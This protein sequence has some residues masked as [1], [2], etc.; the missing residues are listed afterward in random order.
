MLS[1]PTAPAFSDLCRTAAIRR[2]HHQHR[3][4]AFG[5][6]GNEV[7]AQLEAFVAGDSPPLLAKGHARTPPVR[8]AMVFSGNGSQWRGMGQDL[9]ADP[10]IARCIDRVDATISRL[11]GWSVK[12]ALSS[13]EPANL[14]DRTEIAQPAL[15]ALQVAMLEWLAAHGIE[16]EAML[17]HSVGEVSAAYGAGILSLAEACRVIVERSRAQGRTAGTGR[18]AALGLSPE[19][20]AALIAPYGEALTIA[21]VN[22]PNSVTV[23]G[24]AAAI[25]A[26]GGELEGNQVFFR[27]LDLDY[28]FHSR[29]MD[30]IR[31]GLLDRLDGLTPRDGRLRFVSTVTGTTIEGSRLDA[32]YWWDNIRRPV[33]FA[34]A[35]ESLMAEGFNVF[36]EIGPHPI[37]DTYLRDCLKTAGGQGVSI[38]TLRRHEPER[39][40]LWLALG[41]CYAAG[42]AIDY[43]ALYPRDCAFVPLPAYPWQRERYWFADDDGE[44]RA[45]PSRRKHP[46]LGKRLPA[47]D[48]IWKNRLDPALLAWLADHVVQ[49]STVLPGAAYIEMAC[50]SVLSTR[51]CDGVEIEAFEIRRPLLIAAGAEPS[52]EVALSAEDGTFR[53]RA[54]DTRGTALPPVAVA[55]ALPLAGTIGTTCPG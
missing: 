6:T 20:A 26:L 18:M 48:G 17:G 35:I 2:T 53:L 37:L 41:R 36:L 24:D 55:R 16:A 5:R 40:A 33:Q 42:I 30:P 9:L 31:K 51:D 38:P 44:A 8:L 25:D 45:S 11:S 21:A 23:A 46:L 43:D 3:L 22:A 34:P 10:F 4:A 29:C 32:E 1:S 7:A 12:D 50:R 15:F 39:D 49:N 47:T 54:N 27:P 19:N 14:F 52:V 28:A 13:T